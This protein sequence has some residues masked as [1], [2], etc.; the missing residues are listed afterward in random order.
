MRELVLAL[1]DATFDELLAAN[2]QL[3][4][5]AAS[6][7]ACVALRQSR[8]ASHARSSSGGSGRLSQ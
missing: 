1:P 6:T 8:D 3:E 7:H 2:P 5:R 4:V